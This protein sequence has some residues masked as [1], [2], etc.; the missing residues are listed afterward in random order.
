MPPLVGLAVK[1]TP[2][3]WQTY[4]SMGVERSTT[5]TDEGLDTDA[6]AWL[7]LLKVMVTAAFSAPVGEAI[8]V[9]DALF[10]PAGMVTVGGKEEKAVV[11]PE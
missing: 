1:V 4:W 11:V 9:K 2:T 6:K 7:V 3:P 8:T 10:A 5:T